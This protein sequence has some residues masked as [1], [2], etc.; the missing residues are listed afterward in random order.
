MA[1]LSVASRADPG[2]QL[3]PAAAV[4][5]DEVLS[6]LGKEM[7]EMETENAR[8]RHLKDLIQKIEIHFFSPT[9][10]ASPR[11][12]DFVLQHDRAS[13]RQLNSVKELSLLSMDRKDL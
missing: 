2:E 11:L 13:A 8:F 6:G 1:S 9:V 4:F 12:I 3:H 5:R 10:A 7:K